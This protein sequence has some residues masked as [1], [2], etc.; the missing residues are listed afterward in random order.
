LEAWLEE[1][2]APDLAEVE[3]AEAE[4]KKDDVKLHVTQLAEKIWKETTTTKVRV[5]WEA[6]QKAAD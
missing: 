3:R 2:P 5:A 6:A 4:K 1:W